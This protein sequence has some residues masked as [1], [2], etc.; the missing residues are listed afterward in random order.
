[1]DPLDHID[2][3]DLFLN[4]ALRFD[5]LEVSDNHGAQAS[6]CPTKSA[7]RQAE[8]LMQCVQP[9]GE[10]YHPEGIFRKKATD[11]A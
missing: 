3:C 4:F 5:G 6:M 11:D 10:N 8:L 9:L 1:M 2:F 7:P